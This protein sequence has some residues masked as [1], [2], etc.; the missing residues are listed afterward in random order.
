MQILHDQA[1]QITLIDFLKTLWC[2]CTLIN[3]LLF[4]HSSGIYPVKHPDLKHQI[5]QVRCV[6][7][8]FLTWADCD[9]SPMQSAALFWRWR[10]LYFWQDL[11]EY[12][13]EIRNSR[14]C[15]ND[16]AFLNEI[17][18]YLRAG[19]ITGRNYGSAQDGAAH[20]IHGLSAGFSEQIEVFFFFFL[21]PGW[22][23][24]WMSLNRDQIYETTVSLFIAWKNMGLAAKGTKI[25]PA[26]GMSWHW[27]IE[28]QTHYERERERKRE[29][30]S[31]KKS[32]QDKRQQPQIKLWCKSVYLMDSVKFT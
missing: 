2:L 13:E 29:G 22:V 19:A 10:G 12:Q 4:T 8:H 5:P 30:G 24:R 14:L 11:W 32:P 28:K 25:L 23:N 1:P 31:G 20:I 3:S 26:C 9:M 7:S 15:Q 18:L 21:R 27:R 16:E 17:Y 6:L